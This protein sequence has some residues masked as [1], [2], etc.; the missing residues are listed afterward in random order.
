MND[1]LLSLGRTYSLEDFFWTGS[2]DGPLPPPDNI[3]QNPIIKTTTILATV[4]LD[5]TSTMTTVMNI[6]FYLYVNIHPSLNQVFNLFRKIQTRMKI[7]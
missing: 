2:G 4:F 1:E 6:L 7:V 3:G 5:A